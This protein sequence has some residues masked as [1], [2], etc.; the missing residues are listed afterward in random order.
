MTALL[1][2]GISGCD[3]DN[4]ENKQTLQKLYKLYKDG[5]IS[6]CKLDGETVYCGST[7]V[8]DGGSEIYDRDGNQIGYC[9]YAWSTPDPICSDLTDC[10]SIYCVEDNIWGRPAVDK[11]GLGK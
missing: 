3:R 10:E 9:S 6:E 1:L 4:F 7:Q 2:I 8:Y 5:E 11:Y